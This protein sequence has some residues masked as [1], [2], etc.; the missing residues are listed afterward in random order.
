MNRLLGYDFIPHLAALWYDDAPDAAQ[1]RADYS[2]AIR[3][4]LEE[5]FYQPLHDW[6]SKHDVALMGHPAAA[7]D[8]AHLRFFQIPGQ[9]VVWRTIVPGPSATDHPQ[10]TTAKCA[11]SAAMHHDRRRNSM[12]CFGAYGRELTWDEMVWL[13]NW[14]FVRGTNMIIPHAFYYSVR[15]PRADER[16]PDVGPN[17]A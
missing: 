14:C 8:L 13:A 1:R 9:D 4:R 6:C 2:R 17:S 15:G 11:S 10:S 3:M 7:D 5:T 12:E 16:P